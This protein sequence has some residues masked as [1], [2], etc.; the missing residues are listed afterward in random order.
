MYGHKLEDFVQ[1]FFVSLDDLPVTVEAY[2]VLLEHCFEQQKLTV[3]LAIYEKMKNESVMPNYETCD[4]L[5]S[6]CE[7]QSEWALAVSVAQD[8]LAAGLSADLRTYDWIIKMCVKVKAWDI[9]LDL[10][11]EMILNRLEPPPSLQVFA[12]Q[13]CHGQRLWR[14]ALDTFNQIRKQV[15]PSAL[16][17]SYVIEA[18]L[19]AGQ[20]DQAR[21]LIEEHE[22]LQSKAMQ[23]CGAMEI[24]ADKDKDDTIHLQDSAE[25]AEDRALGDKS[26]SDNGGEDENRSRASDE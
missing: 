6:I 22:S 13:A 11:D 9:V 16:P 15:P 17:F 20:M 26:Q 10:Y 23:E 2:N 19:A 5:L 4:L 21:K 18:C 14:R 12:I 24:A 1:N 7:Q 25:Q 3:A 8:M